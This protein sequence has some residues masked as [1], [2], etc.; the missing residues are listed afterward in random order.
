MRQ[1]SRIIMIFAAMAVS[2]IF[3]VVAE[4]KPEI[5]NYHGFGNPE[6]TG[7]LALEDGKC[8]YISFNTLTAIADDTTC[9]PFKLNLPSSP[10]A[11][12]VEKDTMNCFLDNDM[13]VRVEVRDLLPD[14]KLGFETFTPKD[15]S[16]VLETLDSDDLLQDLDPVVYKYFYKVVY[17][18]NTA[19]REVERYLSKY[20]GE[21][22]KLANFSVIL[23]DAKF[24]FLNVRPQNVIDCMRI[25]GSYDPIER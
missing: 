9:H 17:N 14:E 10:K 3:T 1:V 18:Y 25:V 23:P 19:V 4:E 7:F 2:A 15:A 13:Y 21:A 11:Y 8:Q 20:K 5:L 16:Y 12:W 22:N 6:S 24:Y